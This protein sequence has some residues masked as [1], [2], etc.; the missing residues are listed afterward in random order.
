MAHGRETI[1]VIEPAV[2]F[3][4]LDCFNHLALISPLP[5]SYHLPA[6]FGFASLEAVDLASLSG[7]IVM[8]SA[9][10]ANDRLPW[11]DRLEGWLREAWS[12]RVPTLGICYGHQMI[13]RM[14][15][16][17]VGYAFPGRAKARGFRRVRLIDPPAWAGPPRA[18]EL[19]VSH[20]EAVL[21]C[22]S[23]LRVIAA[24]D[25]VAVDGFAHRELPIFGL[26]PHPEATPVF[27]QQHDIAMASATALL[28][29]GE[30]LVSR[31]LEFCASL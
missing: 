21:E 2:R 23:E 4:N 29:D 7:V 11:Q 9:A 8:G 18:V 28:A 24:S 25:E 15:G 27:L 3:P 6:L 12:A 5:L 19:C 20:R 1:A 22:P 26:Q 30:Q 31:Y 14:F 10:S 16:A 17:S 13:A